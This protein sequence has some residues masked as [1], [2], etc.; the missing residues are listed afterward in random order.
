MTAPPPFLDAATL[1]RLLP[2]RAAVDALEAALRGGLDPEADPPRSSMPAR[3]G[4][5]LVMPSAAAVAVGVKLATVAPGNA[6]RGLPRIQGVYALFDE[7]T[8]APAAI[9]DGIGLTN[10]R[11]AAVSA[12]AARHL[13]APDARRLVVFGTGP[14]ARAHVEALRAV[15]SLDRVDVVGRRA[16]AA[17][18]LAAEVG[19]RAADASAVAAADVVCCCTT[20]REPLFAGDDVPDH[21][22]VIAIGSHEPAAREVDDRLAARAAAVVVESRASAL[23]EAGDVIQ[24]IEA[25]ALAPDDLVGLAPLVRGEVSIPAG[26]RL[27]KSTGMAWE[28]LVIAA[29]VVARA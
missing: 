4:E 14:Q 29:A 20:A 7:E 15:L 1:A 25:G 21:T 26:P 24:A 11:T 22:T 23:R 3:G 16:G 9:L 27:F 10:V 8:L 6:E 18:A 13:A 28:D 19:A 5:L 12:L 2:P 17:A